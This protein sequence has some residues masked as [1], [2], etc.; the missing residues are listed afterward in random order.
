MVMK[1]MLFIIACVIMSGIALQSCKPSDTTIQRTV[2]T[3]LRNKSYGSVTSSV[4]NGIVTLTGQVENEQEKASIENTV[5]S[6]KDVKSVVSEIV[7]RPMPTANTTTITVNPDETI[8]TFITSRLN[9]GNYKN[10][11]VEVKDGEVTLTGDLK[12]ADLTKV[13]QI[14]NEAK[15]KKVNNKLNLK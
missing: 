15:A 10:V 12:R 9:E 14:A 4:R 1:K 3:E 6:L 2:E 8:N 11:K 7:V 5:K 13:M